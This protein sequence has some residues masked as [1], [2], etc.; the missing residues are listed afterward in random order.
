MSNRVKPVITT[1]ALS[2]VLVLAGCASS[3][4]RSPS[5]SARA[6][7]APTRVATPVPAATATATAATGANSVDVTV[8][9]FNVKTSVAEASAGD[10]TFKV[11]NE[12]PDDQHEFVVI[13]TDLRP[14]NLPTKNNGS[15][16]EDGEGI[17]VIDELEEM[18]VGATDE[19]TVSLQPGAYVLICNVYDAEENEAHYQEGMRT[20]FTVE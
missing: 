17:E 6:S 11:T 7:A 9:E 10:V 13:K 19:L 1:F 20:A 2:S 16:D 3:P 8:M 4:A 12:G 15:V 18:D 5:G 14:G